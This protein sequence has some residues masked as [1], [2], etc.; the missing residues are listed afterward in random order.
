MP[1][2]WSQWGVIAF[3]RQDYG[4]AEELLNHTLVIA[5]QDIKARYHLALLAVALGQ[6]QDALDLLD[7]VVALDPDF[8]ERPR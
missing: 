1:R 5:P 4:T 7:R 3:M 2:A 8:L 6:R